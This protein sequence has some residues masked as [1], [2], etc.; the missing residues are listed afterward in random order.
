MEG[1]QGGARLNSFPRAGLL[2]AVCP[3]VCGAKFPAPEKRE[4]MED[5][6]TVLAKNAPA[7]VS[8]PIADQQVD[9]QHLG[10]LD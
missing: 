8:I 4:V 3:N 5:A 1:T 2:T 10:R 9:F 6:G 7:A